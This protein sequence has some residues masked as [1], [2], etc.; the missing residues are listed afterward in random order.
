MPKGNYLKRRSHYFSLSCILGGLPPFNFRDK[1]TG[2][3]L[4]NS[5]VFHCVSKLPPGLVDICALSQALPRLIRAQLGL[6]PLLAI[7]ARFRFGT[8]HCYGFP[9]Y[10]TVLPWSPEAP[11]HCSYPLLRG[12]SMPGQQVEPGPLLSELLGLPHKG[13]AAVHKPPSCV[14]LSCSCD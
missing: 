13:Q 11:L 3:C 9:V 12:S 1:V 6:F 10:Y 8:T 7:P 5:P 4:L 14:H 2:S